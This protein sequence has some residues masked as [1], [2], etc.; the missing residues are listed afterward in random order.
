MYIVIMAILCTILISIG[1]LYVFAIAAFG[2]GWISLIPGIIT[3]TIYCLYL[4]IIN[5][6]INEIPT[7]SLTQKIFY[8]SLPIIPL[9]AW[10]IM[11]TNN[12]GDVAMTIIGI[13]LAP[14]VYGYAWYTSTNATFTDR[15][16]IIFT[17]YLVLAVAAIVFTIWLRAT[18]GGEYAGL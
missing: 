8:W 2:G 15:L 13:A 14:L 18:Y 9:I 7:A 3:V 16:K 10:A 4:Y 1:G 11:L 12:I 5:K 6:K 17:L